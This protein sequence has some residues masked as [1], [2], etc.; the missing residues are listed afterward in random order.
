[1]GALIFLLLVTT[2]MIREK[3][4]EAQ[5]VVVIPDPPLLEIPTPKP[6][7]PTPRKSV[8]E[9]TPEPPSVQEEPHPQLAQVPDPP[10]NEI[11]PVEKPQ[12]P[13]V[14]E[15]VPTLA[16]VIQPNPLLGGTLVWANP[17]QTKVLP[18]PVD[19]N[20]ALKKTVTE[21]SQAEQQFVNQLQLEQATR[22]QREQK[23]RN[24]ETEL[25]SIADRLKKSD[26]IV[27]A[28]TVMARNMLAERKRLDAE[29]LQ[30]QQAL[31]DSKVKRSQVSSEFALVPYDGKT[32]TTRRPILL[33]CREN[34]IRFVAEDIALTPKQ[35]GGFLPSYNPLLAGTEALMM[36]WEKQDTRNSRGPSYPPYV[37]L[38]VRPK[39]TVSFYVARKLLAAMR[40]PFGYELIEA[41]MQLTVPKTDPVATAA[42][43]E[44]VNK[45]LAEKRAMVKDLVKAN[46]SGPTGRLEEFD[47]SG[48]GYLQVKKDGETPFGEQL[49]KT[50]W[51]EVNGKKSVFNKNTVAREQYE[52]QKNQGKPGNGESVRTGSGEFDSP[53]FDKPVGE[54]LPPEPAGKS[55]PNSSSQPP[56]VQSFGG[57][58]PLPQNSLNG[59]AVQTFGGPKPTTTQGTGN[60][61]VQNFGGNKQL[62]QGSRLPI[63]SPGNG[64]T[65]SQF[66]DQKLLKPE[67]PGSNE[68]SK[69]KPMEY[70]NL[71][72]RKPGQEAELPDFYRQ[73]DS[74]SSPNSG[75]PSL[76]PSGSQPGIQ[77]PGSGKGGANTNSPGQPFQAIP[78]TFYNPTPGEAP[79]KRTWGVPHTRNGIGLERKVKISVRQDRLLIGQDMVVPIKNGELREDFV[80]RL[81]RALN[82]EASSWGK[83][84]QGFY[85]VPYV[86]FVVS[87]G[88][89]IHH[90]RVHEDLKQQWGIS[91]SVEQTLETNP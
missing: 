48:N 38:I 66:G 80:N 42:C 61:R 28:Q 68:F 36:Y 23:K 72:S 87:P 15:P 64:G 52:A 13:K 58:K 3:A 33:E 70:S 8:P 59:P 44:A 76:N 43:R 88:G 89:N 18:Q 27:N 82:A 63:N 91:S 2:R 1:M 56:G 39:G 85:W 78:Q 62:N 49:P 34:D 55:V 90:Q 12:P 19:P 57:P 46:T 50:P 83:P 5:Q 77:G 14:E 65:G 54:N 37:L 16:E 7:E 24:A 35:L 31:Q 51:D 41:D 67:S 10:L 25:Q 69:I 29:L 84:P 75:Q 71:P 32:G 40:Q 81:G 22:R 17:P 11:P 26:E 4:I 79:Q 21:L 47:R 53:E 60:S 73:S 20:V 45:L 86:N 9:K 6:V 30:K 74:F